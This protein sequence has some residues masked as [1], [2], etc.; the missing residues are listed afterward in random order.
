EGKRPTFILMNE[1]Q[2]WVEAN[3]GK[4]MRDVIDGNVSKSA[5]GTCRA[6]S[7]CNAHIPGQDSVGEADWETYLKVQAGEA[8]DT[9]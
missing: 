5:Y 3:D 6:L 8:V 2:W 4:N 1:T 7:I 9:G